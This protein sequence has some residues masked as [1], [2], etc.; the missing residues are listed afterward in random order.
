MYN[1]I[2]LRLI[3]EMDKNGESIRIEKNGGH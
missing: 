1:N 3:V 2:E